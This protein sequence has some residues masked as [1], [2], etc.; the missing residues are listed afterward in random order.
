MTRREF[1]VSLESPR[2]LAAVILAGV[3]S[4]TLMATGQLE[5]WA[6]ALQS[7]L[8]LHAVVFRARPFVW[9]RSPWVLNTLLLGAVAAGLSV[10]RGGSGSL[11][12]LAHFALLAQGLQL[13]DARPRRSEFLLVA[14]ALFQ[15]ILASNLTDSLLFAPLLALFL[16]TAVWTLIVHTLRTEAL[17]A[18]TPA[19]ADRV[20][21]PALLRT[22]VVA[23]ILSLALALFLFLLFPRLP[24]HLVRGPLQDP[25]SAMAGFS[26][27]VELGD[28]GRIRGDP[29][30]LLRVETLRGTPPPRERAYWRGLAF[31]SFDGRRWSVARSERRVLFGDPEIGLELGRGSSA[32][33][34]V[35]RVVRE[36][37]PSGVLFAVPAPLSVEGDLGRIL[38]DRN[39]GIYASRGLNDRVRY[40]VASD[41]HQP[42]DAELRDDVAEP[43]RDG[44]RY[45]ELPPLSSAVH[46]IALE[47]VGDARSDAD[48]ARAIESYLRRTGHY[49]DTPP[50]ID[51]KDPRSP[52]EAFLLGQRAGH[53]EYFASA[54]AVLARSLG[55]PAR[56]VNGLAG[57]HENAI[58]G[59]VELTHSDAHA[60]VEIHYRHAGW[61]TYDPTP[62]DLRLR[63]EPALG[64]GERL[65]ELQSAFELWWFQHVVNFDRADQ[66]RGL[67]AVWNAWHHARREVPRE[68]AT[69]GVLGGLRP[70]LRPLAGGILTA[71][72]CGALVAWALRRRRAR[73]TLPP[74]YA[75]ALRLLARRGLVREAA[76]PARDFARRAATRL[77]EPAA[78]AFAALTERYLAE[79]FGGR[80]GGSGGAEL[81]LLRDSLRA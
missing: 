79:R 80:I 67:R 19:A 60:W 12:A 81:R 22:T 43:P 4:A 75:A 44:E 26:D 45:L 38:R 55:L 48:R 1:R 10:A 53:C 13:L 56:L 78:R 69:R 37:V 47:A 57:G 52:I 28:L 73:P 21:T 31:D 9:Q 36:P 39:G 20:L 11:V 51:P 66:A 15:V 50:R 76:L 64:I 40:T 74:E 32:A 24:G 54:M 35:Q 8:L 70:L 6:A 30:V 63:A 14:L 2:P 49:T 59:F 61:V 77:P 7:L 42:S 23:S 46:R 17:E 33:D 72:A 62:P 58:G 18:G 68:P 41:T 3:A 34:L 65:D 29:S 5:P 25:G 16:P 27:R 71:L